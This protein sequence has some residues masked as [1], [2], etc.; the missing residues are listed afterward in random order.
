M[1]DTEAMPQS[2]GSLGVVFLRTPDARLLLVTPTTY[3]S[4]SELRWTLP[5]CELHLDESPQHA[6]AR[7]SVELGVHLGATPILLGETTILTDDGRRTPWTV[8]LQYLADDSVTRPPRNGMLWR[9]L[10]GE[11]VLPE[12]DRLLARALT[13]PDHAE[14]ALI[15][16]ARVALLA[17]HHADTNLGKSG[18][19]GSDPGWSRAFWERRNQRLLFLQEK[20]IGGPTP[21]SDL[22]PG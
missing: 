10:I 7:V 17:D 8:I 1:S 6:A 11:P 21:T 5:S 18:L 14:P 19:A 22:V 16:M 9:P 4:C 20:I 15:T 13:D 12:L 2:T 3:R